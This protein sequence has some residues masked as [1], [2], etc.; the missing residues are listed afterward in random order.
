MSRIWRWA[1]VLANLSLIV[2]GCQSLGLEYD[3]PIGPTD[4]IRIQ[5][6]QGLHIQN[7]VT[8]RADVERILGPADYATADGRQAAYRWQ[9]V[10]Y[11]Q[12][13]P[14]IGNVRPP[15]GE[16]MHVAYTSLLLQ[17]DE[18]GAVEAHRK[19]KHACEYG[20]PPSLPQMLIN[21]QNRR[22]TASAQ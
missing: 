5:R 8:T 14:D 18:A 17:F 12:L 10:H 4:D 15:G 11:D 21:W 16:P 2:A 3:R 13:V 9:A 20:S 22:A 7:G 6:A 19:R 1:V